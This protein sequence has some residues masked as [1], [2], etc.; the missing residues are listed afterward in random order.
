MVD[1][2]KT[3]V[4]VLRNAESLIH[5]MDYELKELND[6]KCKLKMST[7]MNFITDGRS[8]TWAV[9]K[10][11]SKIPD[12]DNWYK[13]HQ[14]E[15]RG[16]PLLRYFVEVRNEI[17][18][19]GVIRA[20][21]GIGINNLYAGDLIRDNKPPE[22]YKNYVKSFFMCDRLGGSGWDIVLPDGTELKHYIELPEDKCIINVRL[23]GLPKTHLGKNIEGLTTVE[24]CQL[25]VDYLR[26][27]VNSAKKQFAN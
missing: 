24:I 16:D 8:V 18:K 3:N 25:Y 9:Q 19:E 5:K 20:S 21:S 13:K 10:Q 6:P 12:F 23:G 15:M 14:D 2:K 26:N 11:K 7:L 22:E 27:I 4:E 1:S 17:E